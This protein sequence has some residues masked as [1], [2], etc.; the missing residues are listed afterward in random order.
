MSSGLVDPHSPVSLSGLGTSLGVSGPFSLKA[1]LE[2][3]QTKTFT[4]DITSEGMDALSGTVDFTI[5]SNGYYKVHVHMHDAGFTSYKFFNAIVLTSGGDPAIRFAIHSH[6]EVEGTDKTIPL[7]H[8][9]NREFYDDPRAPAPGTPDTRF[10][11]RLRQNWFQFKDGY[12]TVTTRYAYGGIV[13]L[14]ENVVKGYFLDFV[15]IVLG[16]ELLPPVFGAIYLTALFSDFSD[17]LKFLGESGLFGL[18]VA[19]GAF[20]LCG[21]AAMFPIF[22]AAGIAFEAAGPNHRPLMQNEKDFADTLFNGTLDLDSIRITDAVGLGGR[23]FT[24]PGMDGSIIINLGWGNYYDDL[25]Q[26]VIDNAPSV[27]DSSRSYEK[28]DVVEFNG[29]Y[30]QSK[31]GS[32]VNHD[33]FQD[34]TSSSPEFWTEA[35][36]ASIP[37]YH[38]IH[39]MVHAWEI[40]NA[41]FA[42]QG[43]LCS[44][45]MLWKDTI[46]DDS[47][48]TQYEYGP[49]GNRFDHAFNVEQ[50]AAVVTDWFFGSWHLSSTP[51]RDI[52]KPQDPDD[53][54]FRYIR[55]N[56]W[57]GS[58]PGV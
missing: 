45:A 46:V 49:P 29:N 44:E 38:F 16:G 10:D 6:G 23:P 35:S 1:I 53:P 13:G 57:M 51:R 47:L 18:V 20:V 55:D 12:L 58:L 17:K 48:K 27:F 21:P 25:T 50:R 41:D 42:G 30:Y 28:D 15:G 2:Q 39:E 4:A 54:Y 26:G 24:V 22:A 14:A 8:E 36:P 7:V 34:A 52:R 43:F 32:N 56:I 5:S 40:Q 33:P 19:G 9:P 3:V 37:G 11:D 31:R